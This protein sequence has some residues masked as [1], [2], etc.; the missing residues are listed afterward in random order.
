IEDWA[1]QGLGQLAVRQVVGEKAREAK[2]GEAPEVRLRA[3]YLASVETGRRFVEERCPEGEISEE[4][5]RRVWERQA[6]RGPQDWILVRHIFKQLPAGASADDR[7]RLRVEM[8]A[9]VGEL[10]GGASFIEMARRH[11][12]SETAETGGLIGRISRQAPMDRAFVDAAWALADGE[13]GPLLELA[14]GFHIILRED[15]GVD[16]PKAYATAAPSIRRALLRARQEA[17]GRRL[18][19]AAAAAA[20]ARFPEWGLP[21]RPSPDET[22]LWVGEESF[23]AGQL[24]AL[25]G[26]GGTLATSQSA[27]QILQQFAEALLLA[28][29]ARSESVDLD[30]R[31]R[32]KEEALCRQLAWEREWR[33]ARRERVAA[34]GEQELRR[35]FDEHREQFRSEIEMDVGMILL[36]AS[37]E[38]AAPATATLAAT[39]AERAR[40]GESFEE[41][42][43]AHSEHPSGR[44]GG[45]LGP[46][47][48]SRASVL[49]G[50]ETVKAAAALAAGE[51]AGP[52]IVARRPVLAYAV[53]RL[54]GR[55]EP[56]EMPFEQARDRVVDALVGRRLG[57]LDVE[58]REA[59]LE[60]ADFEVDDAGLAAYLATLRGTAAP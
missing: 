37:A 3:R 20:P 57:E 50:R 55:R 27:L 10:G 41:L 40:R 12:D 33:R 25:V 35:Y 56:E 51:T 38:R 30:A 58:L 47:P 31:Y 34:R 16:Q 36:R 46:L 23:T 52:L 13:R 2:G 59:V 28:G 32:E 8:E 21:V 48:W 43:R 26:E 15:S 54:Y 42:A 6:S 7:A 17:C 53:V 5:V 9:I 19:D 29:A 39:L 22:L 11:S 45:R 14:G 4:E 1:R 44:E 49:L 24:D 18:L 60:E